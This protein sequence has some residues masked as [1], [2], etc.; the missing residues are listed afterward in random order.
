MKL[1]QISC[2][3]LFYKSLICSPSIPGNP[4]NA[5]FEKKSGA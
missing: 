3:F 5:I 2:R 4:G 1:T